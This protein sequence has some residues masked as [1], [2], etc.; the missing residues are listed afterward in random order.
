MFLRSLLFREIKRHNDIDEGTRYRFG[1]Y[2]AIAFSISNIEI[3]VNKYSIF[4]LK[5]VN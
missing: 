4:H 5:F 2:K 3:I 1:N